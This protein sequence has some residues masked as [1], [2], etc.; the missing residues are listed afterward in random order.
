MDLVTSK[1]GTRIA[2]WSSGSGPPLLLVHGAM[3]DH[4]RFA[5]V[6]APFEQHF[7]V[8]TIDR[9]GRGESEDAADYSIEREYEDVAAVVDFIARPATVLGH[10]YD[11]TCALEAALLTDPIDRLVLY[12]PPILGGASG[13]Y[14]SERITAAILEIERQL[15]EG[16]REAALATIFREIFEMPEGDI[17][18]MK[19]AAEW[20]GRVAAAHTVLRELRAE[21]NWVFD[22]TRYQSLAFPTLLLTGSESYPTEKEGTTALH[23]ALPNSRVVVLEGQGHFAITTAPKLF[24]REVMAFLMER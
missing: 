19:S 6:S 7:T 2:C 13:F 20:P 15:N 17:E 22:P 24:V 4:T 1:D 9:R 18:V 3:A 11:A 10:S 16:E 5:G 12:E 14:Q 21:G 23:A 8:Y